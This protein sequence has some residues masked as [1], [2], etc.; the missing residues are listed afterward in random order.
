MQ[1]SRNTLGAKMQQGD[2]CQ[3]MNP[4]SF[5]QRAHDKL[6]VALQPIADLT[7]GTTEAYEALVRN[8]AEFGI[9]NPKELHDLAAELG[10]MLELELCLW[11]KACVKLA[12][13]DGSEHRHIFLNVDGRTLSDQGRTVIDRLLVIA[14]GSGVQPE[15]LCL[16][17]SGET[18]VSMLESAVDVRTY[19]KSK[20]VRFAI[21]DFGKG[22]GQLKF[23]HELEPDLIKVDRFFIEGIDQDARKHQLVT[24]IVQLAHRLGMRVITEGIESQAELRACQ[25]LNADFA[26]GY[27]VG[28]PQIDVTESSAEIAG[29]FQQLANDKQARKAAE[30][31]S[32]LDLLPYTEIGDGADGII[33]HFK[34]N[35]GLRVLPVLNGQCEP[36]GV[37]REESFRK[38]LYNPYGHMLL[39]NNGIQNVVE[40][41][42][43]KVPVADHRTLLSDL[44][45]TGAVSDAECIIITKDG[46]Y[47]GVIT[48]QTLL[49]AANDDRIKQAEDQNPLTRLPGN[50]LIDAHIQ[51]F[52][53]RSE[54]ERY[55][56]YF[57]FDAFKPFNDA[58]GFSAGDRVIQLFGDILRKKLGQYGAFLGHVG[59]DDFFVG[60][61][62]IDTDRAIREANTIR[63][64]FSSATIGFYSAEDQKLGY[65]R[66]VDR[67]GR[68]NTYGLLSC[69]V[70]IAQLKVGE[71]IT[72]LDR[73]GYSISQIK[74][75]AKA[76]PHGVV[77][78][79]AN[80]FTSQSPA[81]QL[82]DM[83]EAVSG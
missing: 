35:T 30:A 50:R 18:N 44:V 75:A 20:C 10:C 9:D 73:F 2:L 3:S 52:G 6:E 34:S 70:G 24:S 77:V 39:R 36:V 15:K 43:E 38:Y 37:I 51:E 27:F 68:Q 61:H 13:V 4:H 16:E 64:E 56:F 82:Q 28:R 54:A 26:Q 65:T 49:K 32:A 62:G 5:L 55:F 80:A 72:S 83:L 12:D 78:G 19:A 67:S 42:V 60:L 21:D 41:M 8:T 57:D 25:T 1:P 81:T 22:H 76:A 7:S 79:N 45:P 46:K 69:S 11:Q 66:S 29:R 53:Q 23:M 47:I 40:A 63:S 74:K 71:R 58:Y 14:K 17:L 33:E 48:T 31:A 59:G